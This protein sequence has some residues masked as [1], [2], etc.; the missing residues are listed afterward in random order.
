MKQLKNSKRIFAF[1]LFL[2]ACSKLYSQ[3][4]VQATWATQANEYNL[5]TGQRYTF[6][7][8]PNGMVSG[9]V[10]G[11]G[12]YTTDCSIASAAVHAGLIKI[13]NGGNVTIEIIAGQTS[14]EGSI[15]NGVTSFNWG[16]F[17]TSFVFVNTHRSI[18]STASFVSYSNWSTNAAEFSGNIGQRYTF[19]FPPGG[20]IT[21]AVWGTGLYTTDCSIASAAVHAGLLTTQQGGMVTI[22]ILPGQT[23]YIGSV[24]NGVTSRNWPGYGSSFKFV[25]QRNAR[26]RR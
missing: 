17:G 6:N 23:A 2:L 3:P 15:Q 22:E 20:P 16:S 10:W 1:L 14:Y 26:G 12:I 4:V 7:I 25:T 19:Y 13:E 21:G 5:R 18:N 11:T 24:R 9:R 8:P